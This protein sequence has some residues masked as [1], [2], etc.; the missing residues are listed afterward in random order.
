VYLR[1]FDD[2]S[3]RLIAR[4]INWEQSP[5][6][7]AFQIARTTVSLNYPIEEIEAPDHEVLV[8]FADVPHQ[9]GETDE[10]HVERENTN[11][12]RAVRW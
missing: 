9:D 4:E 6:R 10:Q 1:S 2:L 11:A 3:P 12:A 5:K 7:L 8:V